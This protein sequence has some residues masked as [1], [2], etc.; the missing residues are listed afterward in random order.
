MSNGNDLLMGSGGHPWAKWNQVGDAVEGECVAAPTQRQSRDFDTGDP[1][2]WPNGDPKLELLVLLQ[3]EELD[4]DIAGDDGVRAVVLPVG[5]QRFRA[6]QRAVREAGARGIE[7][8]GFLSVKYTGDQPHERRGFN[9]V[10]QFA[11][12]YKAP[13]TP[14]EMPDDKDA[15]NALASFI[16][17][18]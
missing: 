2:V 17:A 16:K 15:L 10:K 7:P 12:T 18:P 8:G 11:A 13:Q 6:V 9:P 14:A 1:A 4:N 3:T 5:T